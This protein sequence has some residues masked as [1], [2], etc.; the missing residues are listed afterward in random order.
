M[1]HCPHARLQH[2]WPDHRGRPLPHSAFGTLG[3]RG[4]AAPDRAQALLR[5]ARP[6]ADRQ[7]HRAAGADGTAEQRRALPLRVHQRGD[8]PVR[9]G[10]CGC[11]HACHSAHVGAGGGSRAGQCALARH[12]AGRPRRWRA[13]QRL[14]GVADPLGRGRR[15]TAGAVHRR[16]RRAG[17]R[18]VD[19]RAPPTARRLPQAA[20]TLSPQ[21]RAVRRPRCPRLPHLVE[22]GERSRARRQRVQREGPLAAPWR[23]LESPNVCPVA[24]THGGHRT[25]IPRGRAG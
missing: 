23:L 21:H 20:P 15:K 12:L 6:A 18:H 4:G 10:G 2:R 7:D 16:D 8:R 24:S 17:R 19:R 3:S 13:A 25:A 5:P 14:A 1:R 22:R 9:A 11:R